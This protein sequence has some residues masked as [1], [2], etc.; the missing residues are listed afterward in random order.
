[1]AVSAHGDYSCSAMTRFP[2]AEDVVKEVAEDG[3][4][5]Y[6]HSAHK[7]ATKMD[8]WAPYALP[9]TKGKERKRLG[10]GPREAITYA[11]PDCARTFIIERPVK[12]R[13]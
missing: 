8:E 12:Q 3:T 4:I 10:P 5:S 11:C 1:M 6:Y 13:T 2:V 9:A 7:P